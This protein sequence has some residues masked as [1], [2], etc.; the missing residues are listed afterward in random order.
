M[1][2][3]RNSLIAMLAVFAVS[4]NTDD[5]QDRPVVEGKDAPVLTAP[6]EGNVYVLDGET[7]DALAERFIWTAANFGTGIIPSY[8]IEID[9]AGENFDTPQVV[10]TTNGVTQFAATHNILN[11]ALKKLEATPEESGTFQ[12]RV[13]AYVNDIVMYSEPVEMLITPFVGEVALQQLYLVGTATEYGFEN[14]AGNAPLFRDPVET[15]KYYFTGYFAAG[16][17]KLLGTLGAW[18]PQY[19]SGGDGVLAVNPG[20]GNDPDPIVISTAGYYTLEVDLTAMTYSVEVFTEPTDV[21]F[22]LVGIIG[23]GTPG[24]WDND[25]DMTVS[26]FN[27]HLWKLEDV[28]IKPDVMKFRANHSWDLPGNWGGG[29][30][31]SGQLTSNGG[32]F[33]GVADEG[34]YNVWFNDLD[35]RYIFIPVN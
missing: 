27:P 4:C 32:D 23:A 31:I 3:L 21:T 5:V 7:P 17:L 12:V 16:D 28:T 9:Y 34:Q 2:T 19:G 35:R 11:E 30:P 14:N 33:V 24:G 20:G 15:N 8:D 25:T 1:K 13:K 10:G 18:Q 6:E 26:T 22:D 29:T